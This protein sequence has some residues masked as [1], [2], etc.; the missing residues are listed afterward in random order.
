MENWDQIW[1]EL[2]EGKC[3]EQRLLWFDSLD[4]LYDHM[5]AIKFIR[6]IFRVL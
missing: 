2:W 6:K 5:K 1:T 4:Y 3:D